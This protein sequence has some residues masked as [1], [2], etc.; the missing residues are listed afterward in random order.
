MRPFDRP[1]RPRGL[2]LPPIPWRPYVSFSAGLWLMLWF[3]INTGPWVFLE[4]HTDLLSWV[5]V[6]RATLPLLV[7]FLCGLVATARRATRFG[8]WPVPL[9]YWLAYGTI[10]LA[11]GFTWPASD[12]RPNVV[13]P[14]YWACAYV[15]VIAA[16]WCYIRDGDSLANAVRLNHLSWIITCVFLLG[17]VFAARAYLFAG[18]GLETT[19]FDVVDRIGTVAEMPMSRS[20]GVARF[21]AVPAVVCFVLM[22]RAQGLKK[23]IWG[24]IV[25][26]SGVM[27]YLMQSRSAIAGLGVALA[28]AL[29][30]LS[31][32]ARV[33]GILL[34]VVFGLAMLLDVIPQNVVAH[35]TH[36]YTAAQRMGLFTGRTRAWEHAWEQIVRSPLWGWGMQA[37][38]ILIREHVHNTYLYALLSSGFA[39]GVFFVMGLVVAWRQ[40][41]RIAACGVAER[42]GQQTTLIQVGAILAFFSARGLAEVS[43]A[44]FGID[45]VLMLPAIA[46]L[47]VLAQRMPGLVR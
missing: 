22:W 37:D 18:G 11:A 15:A 13:D 19:R 2:S 7:L 25:L 46:Y 10:A 34:L 27:V 8:P 16:A 28:F 6:G 23:V 38:R 41:I 40:F 47:G 17:L 43:G 24:G 3:G 29:L 4:P 26:I 45:Y 42:M 9:K 12:V 36:K 1:M 39:G 21:A 44:M 32:R 30:F 20:T 5:H 31:P 14:A 35:L 33:A